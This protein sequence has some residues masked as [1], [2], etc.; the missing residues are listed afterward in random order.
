MRRVAVAVLLSPLLIA[1][2]VCAG[3]IGAFRFEAHLAERPSSS[4]H[5]RAVGGAQ[6]L[7]G[8]RARIDSAHELAATPGSDRESPELRALREA[9]RALF[10]DLVAALAPPP[11]VARSGAAAASPSMGFDGDEEAEARGPGERRPPRPRTPDGAPTFKGS[12]L[13]AG[14]RMPALPVTPHPRTERYV[15]YFGESPEGR[16]LF[17]RV[18]RR[19]GRYRDAILTT[20]RERALPVELIAVAF[21]ESAFIAEAESPAGAMGLWQ[22]MPHT[23]RAYGLAV[24]KHVDERRNPWMATDA[25]VRHLGDLHRRFGTWEEAIAAYNLGYKGLVD[26][27]EQTSTSNF[28]AL[29]DVPDALPTE[30]ALYVPKVMAVATILA[31][32][33]RFGFDDV[34]LLPSVAAVEV[35]GAA[36]QRLSL[37]ARAAGTSVRTLQK[38][39]PDLLGTTVPGHAPG[40]VLASVSASSGTSTRRIRIPSRGFGRFGVMIGPLSEDA[41]RDQIDTKV[42]AE[43]DWG[44]D[45]LLPGLAGR[46]L[47]VG[48]HGKGRGTK[49]ADEPPARKNDAPTPTPVPAPADPATPRA[50]VPAPERRLV[51][52]DVLPGDS[53]ESV[54]RA[55]GLSASDVRVQNKLGKHG[56]LAPGRTLALRLP[57]G[58]S[59][60]KRRAR[61]TNAGSTPN[62]L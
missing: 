29:C 59:P 18:L 51:R 57:T 39:N 27:M 46:G 50:S 10:P 22:F 16:K 60:G 43:F 1:A 62:V 7:A 33:D 8:P 4:P 13:W 23:G 44:K 56:R 58:T 34:D 35:E 36:G 32:L 45:E 26:R 14:L 30:T 2:G 11:A 25:A 17:A 12:E 28:W 15:R 19:S 47:G 3:M 24:D 49:D 31:N 42:A 37:V 53:V 20:L 54:A 48:K 61:P 5:G 40:V 52:Y 6:S 55:F 21:V 38:L 41:E 9:D